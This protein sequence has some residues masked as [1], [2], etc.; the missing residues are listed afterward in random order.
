MNIGFNVF[1]YADHRER[2]PVEEFIDALP[3]TDQVAILRTVLLLKGL[4]VSMGMPHTKKLK[5]SDTM[6]ELRCDRNG[7]NYRVFYGSLGQQDFILL[8]AIA[9]PQRA[10]RVEDVQIAET[11]MRDYLRR[12]FKERLA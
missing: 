3:T 7:R 11:R 4:G 2:K 6:W 12:T 10:I 5:G 1:F 8:H 9:K